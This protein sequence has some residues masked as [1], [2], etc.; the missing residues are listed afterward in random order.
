MRLFILP[1]LAILALGFVA[2]TPA[3]AN[4]PGP[5]NAPATLGFS[6]GYF[7]VLPNNPRKKAVDFR[8]E[9]RSDY[10]MLSLANGR[11]S[12]IEIRPMGGFETTTDGALYGFGGF[13]FDIPIGKH[14]VLSPNEAVGLWYNGNG[15]YL[16]SFVE[17]RSTVEVGYRFD[18]ESR[19]DVAF[20]H[21]SNA[22]L[23][24]QN[25]GVEILSVYYHMPIQKIFGR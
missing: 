3:K 24:S 23:T 16:G 13:V 11:N 8:L 14:F 18:D 6:A 2:A 19:L 9:Y 7:D 15:K 12:W 4:L 10:D 25:H 5:L 20:G 22:G 17:F 1:A 21:I